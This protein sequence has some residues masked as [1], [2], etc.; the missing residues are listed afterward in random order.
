MGHFSR[1][2]IVVAATPA[3]NSI[4]G[5]KTMDTLVFFKADFQFKLE[6]EYIGSQMDRVELNTHRDE[7]AEDFAYKLGAA[8]MYTEAAE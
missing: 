8:Y 7:M 6:V 5:S 2:N 3:T 4:K 1:Y